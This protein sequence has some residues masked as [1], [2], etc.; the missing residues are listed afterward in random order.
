MRPEV[1]RD[2]LGKCY[3]AWN[4]C[5]GPCVKGLHTRVVLLGINCEEWTGGGG[6][7]FLFSLGLG[8]E[9]SGFA[10]PWFLP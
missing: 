2:G 9:M 5:H 7:G 6:A 4:V 8:H 3:R 10:P 1:G